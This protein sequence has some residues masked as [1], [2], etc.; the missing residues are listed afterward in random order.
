MKRERER[1]KRCHSLFSFLSLFL[2]SRHRERVSVYV[3]VYL[4]VC[5]CVCVC[6]C[7]C[8]LRPRKEQSALCRSFSHVDYRRR[9][10]QPFSPFFSPFRFFFCGCETPHCFYQRHSE[11]Q[12][13]QERGRDCVCVC[14]CVCVKERAEQSIKAQ[15]G[16]VLHVSLSFS[17]SSSITFSL[18]L[19]ETMR[20][21]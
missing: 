20:K 4:C 14:V 17:L 2:H 21:R 5:V 1:R 10:D 7:Y 13:T 12:R 6:V 19:F 8:E 9:N 3:A 18:R 15:D 16:R 11:A